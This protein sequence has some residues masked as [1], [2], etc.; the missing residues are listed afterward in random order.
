MKRNIWKTAPYLGLFSLVMIIFA[1]ASLFFSTTL[2]FIE[3]GIAVA[4]VVTS[5]LIYTRFD[6]M[7]R[8]TVKSSVEKSVDKRYL[9]RFGFP[10]VA[11]DNDYLILWYNS[12]FYKTIC[13]ENDVYGYSVLKLL[14]TH[15]VEELCSSTGGDV[16]LGEAKYTVYANSVDNGYIL[17]FFD[18]TYYK[19]IEKEYKDTRLSVAMV[20]IDNIE[21]YDDEDEDDEV[22]IQ[23]QVESLIQRYA[24]EYNALYRKMGRGRYI[25]I[26]E[27]R[28]L[29]KLIENKFDI[30]SKVR[31]IKV[32]D[33]SATIS[34]G[35]GRG[36]ENLRKSQAAAKKA[37]DMSQGRGGDQVAILTEG[38]YEF[39]G[40]KSS[41]V[42]RQS[43]ARVRVITK[44]LIS[45]VENSDKV[46]VM[47]HKFS[48]LDC[49][50]AGIGLCGAITSSFGKPVQ[51][52]VNYNDSMA[53]ALIDFYKDQCP[54]AVFV[55]PEEILPTVTDKTLLIIVDTQ[56]T[57]RL[58]SKALFEAC[59]NIIVIDHHRMSVDH[60]EN[61]VV[62]FHEPSASSASEMVCE[63]IDNFPEDKLK[64][65][66]AEALL[67]G[68][69]L[70]TKN[71]VINSGSRTFEAAAYLRKHGA[72]TVSVRALF[73]ES[74]E[75]YR[76]KY[77][78]VST[79]R[80]YN[81]CAIV[82]ADE[83]MNDIRLIASK[84][85][86]ELLGLKGVNASFV[87]FPT[88]DG[89]I[90]ISAR[91]YGKRNVQLIM[92]ALGG[93]GH[94]SMAAAQLKGLSFEI[95]V[96]RLIEAIDKN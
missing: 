32:G 16:E 92:E 45:A 79:A 22:Q 55:S 86:D 62:F 17:Y 91:S 38:D 14:S 31:S 1:F 73:S 11:V 12:A 64:K 70:D 46:I 19:N 47:G 68:I 37:L 43:K 2:F 7:V 44:S 84:A 15:S 10:V 65:A 71:F 8:N 66:E 52:A 72:D 4:G 42:E 48:D 53:K 54:Q 77:K 69:I 96:R 35:I 94:H 6:H 18:D 57:G 87:V 81:K 50:G 41:G 20:V 40:G 75:I 67:S 61:T 28:E 83:E 95:A 76:N 89:V 74:I 93:G 88:P 23:I 49:V 82:I 27:E 58:E 30:L 59:N 26:I 25:L 51:I 5:V 9:D 3:L 21:A 29:E 36:E 39:F 63:I 90:N 24:T 13:E 80:I 56:S 78:L 33:M 85:A 34:V 60:I